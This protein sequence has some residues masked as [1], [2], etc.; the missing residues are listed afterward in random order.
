MEQL[1]TSLRGRGNI[2]HI[3]NIWNGLKVGNLQIQCFL[4]ALVAEGNLEFS[5]WS[6]APFGAPYFGK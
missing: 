6:T 5:S 1:K 3:L 4:I 2:D